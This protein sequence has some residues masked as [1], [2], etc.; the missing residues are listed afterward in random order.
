M[1]LIHNHFKK[2]CGKCKIDKVAPLL[3]SNHYQFQ[4][5]VTQLKSKEITPI[6]IVEVKTKEASY[7]RHVLFR[8]E[9]YEIIM[10]V[11]NPKSKS[12]VHDHADRGCC[13]LLL[14]G[15]LLEERYCVDD[16]NKKHCQ[17]IEHNSR[18]ATYIDNNMCVLL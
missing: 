9:Q 11:W 7:F 4:T 2:C 3:S 6:E 5:L 14:E 13:M 17:T 12:P 8:N 15:S 1:D 16:G 10:I 18:E